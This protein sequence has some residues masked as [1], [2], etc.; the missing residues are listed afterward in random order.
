MC[1]DLLFP[2]TQHH[3][4]LTKKHFNLSSTSLSLQIDLQKVY[5]V[6]ECFV[7]RGVSVV[8]LLTMSSAIKQ[9]IKKLK[10]LIGLYRQEEF[11]DTKEVIRRTDNRKVKRK[12]GKRDNQ[13]S[14]KHYT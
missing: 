8:K 7:R 1:F 9:T 4:I 5:P 12:R 14:A 10:Y 6:P 3:N 11:E 13:R 2:F